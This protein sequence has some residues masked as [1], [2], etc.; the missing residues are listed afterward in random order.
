MMCLILKI[1][2]A[3]GS[4]FVISA[5]DEAPSVV[6]QQDWV[7]VIYQK[8]WYPG[9]VESNNG[10]IMT[11]NF[12]TRRNRKFSWPTSVDRQMLSSDG[13]LCRLKSPPKPISDRYFTVAN[14]DEIDELCNRALQAD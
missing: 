6:L 11:V 4:A 3:T 13:I 1:I 14:C 7:V 5:V 2:S 12:M 9:L 8:R 10:D